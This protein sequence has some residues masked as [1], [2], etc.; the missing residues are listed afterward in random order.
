MDKKEWSEVK[1]YEM[2][3]RTEKESTP[4]QEGPKL[5]ANEGFYGWFL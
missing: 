3:V 4:E 5:V 2:K 1:V